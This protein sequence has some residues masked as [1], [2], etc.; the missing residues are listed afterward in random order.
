MKKNN[1]KLTLLKIK[2]L[3]LIEDDYID[4]GFEKPLI[5]S[6]DEYFEYLMDQKRMLNKKKIYNF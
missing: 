3:L 4:R 2:R 5:V 1:K 6:E